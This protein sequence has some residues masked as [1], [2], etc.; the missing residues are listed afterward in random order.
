MSEDTS[1]ARS[2]PDR[3]ARAR[4]RELRR[5]ASWYREFAERTGNPDI[6]EARL[7]TAEDLEAEAARAETS[8]AEA[9]SVVPASADNLRAEARRLLDESKNAPDRETKQRLAVHAATLS[10]RAEALALWRE[11]PGI[12]ASDIKRYRAMLDQGIDDAAQRRII[13]Q[14]LAD[15]EAAL[16]IGCVA[17]K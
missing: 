10:Q 9:A 12:I 6:W 1:R 7:R 14:M 2:G 16:T 15:G 17:S 8:L 11:E 4:S 5:L 13:E 3:L